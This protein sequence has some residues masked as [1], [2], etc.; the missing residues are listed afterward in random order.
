MKNFLITIL[1]PILILGCVGDPP[2]DLEELPKGKNYTTTRFE[3]RYGPHTRV[4]ED[5]HNHIKQGYGDLPDSI[6]VSKG[7]R[8][9]VFKSQKAVLKT[10]TDSIDVFDEKVSHKGYMGVNSTELEYFIDSSGELQPIPLNN[11]EQG[12]APKP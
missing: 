7:K 10:T 8:L 12:A 11:S 2:Y 6:S 9:I 5:P 1:L 3:F 4:I